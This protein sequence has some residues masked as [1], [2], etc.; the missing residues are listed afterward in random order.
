MDGGHCRNALQAVLPV[1]DVHVL[2]DGGQDPFAIRQPLQLTFGADVG[3]RYEQTVIK[4]LGGSVILCLVGQVPQLE[5]GF[6]SLVI[7]GTDG[8]LDTKAKVGYGA[9]FIVS[10]QFHLGSGIVDDVLIQFVSVAMGHL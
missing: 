9:G 7:G 5:K 2:N 4:A 8:V 3:A 1:N 10:F 6:V